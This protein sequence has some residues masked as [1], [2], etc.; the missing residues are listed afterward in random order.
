MDELMSTLDCMPIDEIM[1][2]I[3]LN[4]RDVVEFLAEYCQYKMRDIV[5]NSDNLDDSVVGGLYSIIEIGMSPQDCVEFIDRHCRDVLFDFYYN[6][7]YSE[8][9]VN[10]ADERV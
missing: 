4:E 5:A 7:L 3:G 10:D 9:N 2:V 1:A 6:E 8:L